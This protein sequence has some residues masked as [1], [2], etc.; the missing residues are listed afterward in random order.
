MTRVVLVSCS[1]KKLSNR[2]P[3]KN[4]YV[5]ALFRY[6][7]QYAQGL[8]PDKIYILSARYGLVQLYDD[9]ELYNVTLKDMSIRERKEWAE[10]VLQ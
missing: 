4:L 1:N 7:L 6:A 5:G 3:A 10:R 8:S 2:V 9:I